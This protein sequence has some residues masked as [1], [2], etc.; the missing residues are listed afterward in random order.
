MTREC[1]L[2][3]SSMKTQAKKTALGVMGATPWLGKEGNYAEHYT[4]EKGVRIPDGPKIKSQPKIKAQPKIPP[5]VK[6][7]VSAMPDYNAMTKEG[8]MEILERRGFTRSTKPGQLRG[9]QAK[10]AWLIQMAKK[11]NI[12]L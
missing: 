11:K 6:S 7:N 3:D 10:R 9:P 1:L 12:Y 8:L 4:F 5:P 2:M